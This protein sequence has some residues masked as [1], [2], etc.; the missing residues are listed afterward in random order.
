MIVAFILGHLEIGGTQRQISYLA[1][2]LS[3]KNIHIHV[4]CISK[5][6]EPFGS[7][8]IKHG[9]LL[10]IVEDKHILTRICKTI[11]ILKKINPDII[12]SFGDYAGIFALIAAKILKKSHV[13]SVR[14]LSNDRSLVIKFLRFFNV[15]NSDIVTTNSLILKHHLQNQFQRNK[16]SL[17]YVPNGIDI[18]NFLFRS[19]NRENKK[20][21]STKGIKIL[22]IGR[23]STAKDLPTLIKTIQFLDQI[24][25]KHSLKVTL[26]VAG[27]G[28]YEVIKKQINFL[29]NVNILNYSHSINIESLFFICDIVILTSK[30]ESMPNVLLEAGAAAKPVVC[31]NVGGCPEVILNKQTGLVLPAGEAH[32]LASAI[33]EL[34]LNRQLAEKLGKN[35]YIRI[36]KQF[37]LEMVVCQLMTIYESL[38]ANESH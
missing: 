23:N 1:V 8:L 6:D 7:Y 15:N 9:I 3:N 2:A 10:H 30:S 24:L 4:I 16:R 17:L 36:K 22:Y 35:G 33:L 14:S 13:H 19:E 18:E 5:K 31:T 20:I 34:I 11:Q 12:H 38:F 21:I 25:G 28:V 37:S 26:V 29:C 27:K 32:A